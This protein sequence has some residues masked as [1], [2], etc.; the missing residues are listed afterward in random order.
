MG[1]DVRLP[2]LARRGFGEKS[3]SPMQDTLSP[4]FPLPFTA[5]FLCLLCALFC[6]FSPS[7]LSLPVLSPRNSSLDVPKAS[8]IPEESG[9][10]APSYPNNPFLPRVWVPG[11]H[12]RHCSCSRSLVKRDAAL[13][14]RAVRSLGKDSQALLSQRSWCCIR[15]QGQAASALS[16]AACVALHNA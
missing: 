6:V 1:T 3:H 2:G 5:S 8:R 10:T 14:R 12:A 15:K 9:T 7:W 13:C 4:G 11:Q 16:P